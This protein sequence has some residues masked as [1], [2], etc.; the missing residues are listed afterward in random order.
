MNHPSFC[1]HPNFV[2]LLGV[3]WE[4]VES[5]VGLSGYRPSMVVELADERTPTLQS[6]LSQQDRNWTDEL[7]TLT[8]GLL[9]DVAEGV[10]MLHT[11]KIVHGDLKPENVLLFPSSRRLVAK[12][13]DFGFSSPFVEHRDRIGGTLY[14]NA[15]ECMPNA[16]QEIKPFA[17]TLTRDI[18]SYGLIVWRSLFTKLPYGPEGIASD[19]EIQSWKLKEDFL[20]ILRE[21]IVS[22]APG[23]VQLTHP[24]HAELDSHHT[25]SDLLWFQIWNAL[26]E[27]LHQQPNARNISLGVMHR[28]FQ[29]P[30]SQKARELELEAAKGGS[31]FGRV[32]ALT[33]YLLDGISLGISEKEKTEWLRE[34][35]FMVMFPNEFRM[36][37]T[38]EQNR[39]KTA[40]EGLPEELAGHCLLYSFVKS[41]MTDWEVLNLDFNGAADDELFGLVVKEDLPGL[42]R[43]LTDDPSLIRRRTDGYTL[44]HVAA[45][46]CHKDI[47][48]EL[49]QNFKIPPSVPADDGTLPVELAA[50]TGSIESLLLL[51]SL[52]ASSAPLADQATSNLKML[53]LLCGVVEDL[54]A[55]DANPRAAVQALLDGRYKIPGQ[56]ITD[57]GSPLELAISVLNYDSTLALLNLGADPNAVNCMTPL[58]VAVSLREPVLAALLLA[59]GADVNIRSREIVGGEK[60]GNTALHLADT[61]SITALFDPPRNEVTSY[62][63]VVAEGVEPVDIDTED[64][65]IARV[66]GCIVVLLQF[67]ADVNAQNQV[68]ETPLFQRVREGDFEIAKFLRDKGGNL[69]SALG[70]NM[71]TVMSETA[72]DWCK[73]QG[74]M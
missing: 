20:S 62:S 69:G 40:L 52:G 12:I 5:D 33:Y 36:N 63:E 42:R 57:C 32:K 17:Q 45:D 25:R 68:G 49:V 48:R 34:S 14:W 29:T 46:Y 59:Y 26:V 3:S 21:N 43:A 50:Q 72:L 47:I 55:D 27:L 74:L 71:D 4:R 37:T 60:E 41:C 13:S 24:I 22:R 15:P 58:H 2:D 65:A 67:G 28:I 39:F 44:L 30:A 18:Y 73:H 10:T 51:I 1:A 8:F 53:S 7:Q 56:E 23:L 16:P 38:A 54:H 64:A 6:F 11:T 66:K 61:T 19:Q 35:L 70:G 31:D 9:T